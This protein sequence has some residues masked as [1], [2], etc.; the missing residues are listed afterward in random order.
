MAF[1][2][3]II[4]N[5]CK[6][7]YKGGYM[8]IRKEDDTAKVH[9]D[10]IASVTLQTN[11]AF[12]SA[13]LLSELAKKKIS[14]VVSDEKRNPI[15]QYL[16]LYGAHNVSKRIGEQ[17]EWSE[18]SKKRVWQHVVQNKI[19]N[20]AALLAARAKEEWAERLYTFVP[21]VRSGDPTNREG[22]AARLYFQALFGRGFS[23]DDETPL[24]AALNY[25]Y[26][27]LLSSVNREIVARGY[28]TQVGICHRNE[29]NLYNL[30]CDLMEPFRPIVDRL[31]FDNVD[32]DFTKDE[33]RLLVDMLNMAVPYRSGSYRVASVISLYVQD[34]LNALGKRLSVDEIEPFDVT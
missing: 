1:R 33:K 24:N 10:D 19:S 4:E 20:Q 27:I 2:N 34:C 26:A 6:C 30:S 25:G 12:I 23:R 15:G 5:P 29:Y 21:E 13:Y 31:V 9:L 18:P 3:V 32:G 16:P 8:V 22:A 14:F 11:Q 17:L 28:L 7:T